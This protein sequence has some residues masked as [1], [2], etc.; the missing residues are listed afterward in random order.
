MTS[1][2]VRR[3]VLL[4]HLVSADLTFRFARSQG[5]LP[6]VAAPG[7]VAGVFDGFSFPFKPSSLQQPYVS[8]APRP[9]A[10]DSTLDPLDPLSPLGAPPGF[11]V[12]E[13]FKRTSAHSASVTSSSMS[14]AP[15]H[16]YEHRRRRS[17]LVAELGIEPGLLD[18]VA[19]ALGVDL[20]GS[21]AHEE[22]EEGGA[23]VESRS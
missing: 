7:T 22:G 19:R 10:H 12:T 8:A 2:R 3:L 15:A 5:P 16:N 14:G 6:H 23:P 11:T 9:A 21:S 17:S 4:T 18:A 20:V 13:R 1:M